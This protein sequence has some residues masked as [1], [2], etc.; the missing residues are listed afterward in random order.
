MTTKLRVNVLQISA[1]LDDQEDQGA[2]GIY[3]VAL[4]EKASR[5]PERKCASIAL[6]VFH[7]HVPIGGLDDFAITVLDEQGRVIAEDGDHEDYSGSHEGQVLGKIS[8][9]P[10][11]RD[12]KDA[13]P[14][15]QE[16][17]RPEI[18][19][20]FTLVVDAYACSEY[21]AGPAYAVIEIGPEFWERIFRLLGLC[22]T[23]SLASCSEWRGPDRWD[24][25]EDLRL[26][27]DTLVV[28]RDS[29]WFTAR[30]KHADYDVETRAVDLEELA[31]A[32]NDRPTIQPSFR[33]SNGTLYYAGDPGLLTDLI[34]MYE[35]AQQEPGGPH[36]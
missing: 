9:T 4:S 25:A 1:E 15:A 23:E 30:P 27:S 10:L 6:D 2:A 33:W 3:E 35:H 22:R 19:K 26:V 21:G 13:V 16:Y 24:G 20:P 17:P 12:W 31:N 28:D 34:D 11:V 32:A 8:D 5:M 36:G 14:A 18:P 29:F 7:S